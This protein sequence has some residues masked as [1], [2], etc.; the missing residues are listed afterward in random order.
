MVEL[1]G[2]RNGFVDTIDDLVCL[3]VHRNNP[4]ERIP[5]VPSL[6]WRENATFP[7][8]NVRHILRSA[9]DPNSVSK[10]NVIICHGQ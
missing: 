1:H 7:D 3:Y 10:T 8:H 6:P 2:Q 5:E 4:D 9:K